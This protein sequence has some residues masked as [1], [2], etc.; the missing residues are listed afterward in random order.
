[1]QNSHIQPAN[2][3]SLRPNTS[4][5]LHAQLDEALTATEQATTLTA[6]V[7]VLMPLLR[8]LGLAMLRVVIEQRERMTEMSCSCPICG[9][10]LKRTYNVRSVW[11]YTLLG[12]LAYFRRNYLCIRCNASV[13]PTDLRL[14]IAERLHGHSQEFGSMVVLLTTLL[15]NA[16]AMDLFAKCFGFDVSTHLSRDLTME[17]GERLVADEAKEAERYWELRT[18]DPEALEPPR[19]ELKKLNRHK[20]IYVMMDDSKLGIQD[21]ARGRGAAE[22]KAKESKELETLRQ[23]LAEEKGKAVK[24][25][26][27]G[28]PGVESPTQVPKLQGDS[29]YRNARALLIFSEA[30]LAGVSKGR[31]QI[32][33]RRV[34]AHIGIQEEWRKL[35]HMALCE[36]G[37]YTAEEVVCI[38]DGGGGIW[39]MF[40]ELL[41]TT[42]D[43][44]VVQLLDFYHGSSHVWAAARAYK[45]NETDAQK[46]ACAK[47][48]KPLLKELR[49]GQVANVIQRLGKLKL[50]GKAATKV[51]KVMAY[52][53]THRGRMRYAWARS[54][55]MLIGSGA[56]ES[57]HAWAIQ[58]RC[59]LPGMRWSVKGANVMLRLR[60]AWA[61]QRW[62]E[63]FAR[64]AA[65]KPIASE[66]NALRLAA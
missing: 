19:A 38:A 30:D 29:G 43:R 18:K 55:G 20:R 40:G 57:V 32:L 15:P 37:V 61:S 46:K 11:R 49:H 36:E 58:A 50:T 13:Y 9:G 27:R 4:V 45:G 42:S 48:V 21:G 24:A 14:G 64:A 51:A 22:R 31:S 23:M 41:P 47:W 1:M 10:A 60:C 52:L 26:K 54:R 6:M 62:D 5:Q 17:I 12:R 8:L 2:D 56:M 33:R 25:A 3:N 66:N 34:V 65:F 7:T 59:R 39:E 16:K 63:S 35:V 44:R 28:K 53:T